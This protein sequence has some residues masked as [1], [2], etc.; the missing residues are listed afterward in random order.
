M[1]N[2]AFISIEE[3]L[4][5]PKDETLLFDVRSAVGNPG[6]GHELYLSSHASGARYLSFEGAFSGPV[7]GTNG[8]NPWPSRE[9]VV[10]A[11]AAAGASPDRTIVFMDGGS[12]PYACRAWVCTKQ[13]GYPRVFVLEGGL[14]RWQAMDLPVESGEDRLAKPEGRAP[15]SKGLPNLE[16]LCVEA[17]HAELLKN[18]ARFLDARP[19]PRWLG[20]VEPVDPFPGRIPG[21]LNRPEMD[22]FDASGRLKSPET[23]RAEFDALLGEDHDPARIIHLCGSGVA[24][25]LNLLAF[26]LAY[27]LEPG[28]GRLYPGSWSEWCADPTRPKAVGEPQRKA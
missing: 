6:V 9:Q 24:A 7:T 15:E 26:D 22:N 25:C 18:H 3:F 13:A 27:G 1:Q 5:L 14:A 12:T 4:A 19:H 28:T 2:R 11:L 21:S 10:E 23:L 16:V 8:R 17:A 20:V